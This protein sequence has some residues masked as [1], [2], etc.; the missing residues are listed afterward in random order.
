MPLSPEDAVEMTRLALALGMATG[1]YNTGGA[2]DAMV[3]TTLDV[4]NHVRNNNG[5]L[6][7]EEM[8]EYFALVGRM[9]YTLIQD[10]KNSKE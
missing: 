9:W 1:E 4:V 8:K 3:K 10:K 6:T 2:I 5:E 7:P